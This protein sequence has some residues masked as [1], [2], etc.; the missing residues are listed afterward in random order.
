MRSRRYIESGAMAAE[1]A[2]LER[3]PRATG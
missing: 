2:R 3:D 1:Y